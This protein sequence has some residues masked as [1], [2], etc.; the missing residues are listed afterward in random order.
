MKIKAT[1][2]DAYDLFHD[3]ILALARAECTMRLAMLQ[4]KEVQRR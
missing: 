2:A 3:G 1:T 4:M